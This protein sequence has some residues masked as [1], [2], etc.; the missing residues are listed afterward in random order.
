MISVAILKSEE[1]KKL[2]LENN[3]S[4]IHNR[5]PAWSKAALDKTGSFLSL[6]LLLY[7]LMYISA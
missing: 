1:A 2:H 4:Q 6:T 7:F 5:L 3:A